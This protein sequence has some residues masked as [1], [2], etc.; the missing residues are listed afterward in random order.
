MLVRLCNRGEEIEG[1]EN[2]AGGQQSNMDFFWLQMVNVPSVASPPLPPLHHLCALSVSWGISGKGEKNA[3]AQRCC[4]VTPRMC[5]CTHYA[6]VFV[7]RVCCS[8]SKM[9]DVKQ[10]EEFSLCWCYRAPSQ[11][12]PGQV[13]TRNSIEYDSVSSRT[14]EQVVWTMVRVCAVLI[15]WPICGLTGVVT[16]RSVCRLTLVTFTTN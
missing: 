14:K 1:R 2:G 15:R 3:W 12:L 16:S 5:Y 4:V 9:I 10:R 11:L 13:L 6:N 7:T 8:L